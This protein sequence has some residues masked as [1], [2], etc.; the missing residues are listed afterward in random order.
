MENDLLNIIDNRLQ[1]Y[2]E[3]FSKAQD[4]KRYTDIAIYSVLIEE[5]NNILDKYY[6][7]KK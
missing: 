3:K 6:N 1:E 4:E 5:L 2:K 7:Y